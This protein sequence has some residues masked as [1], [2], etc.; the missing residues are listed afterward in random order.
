[1]H[2][3]I[4]DAPVYYGW[5]VTLACFLSNGVV[6]GMTYSFGVFTESLA[7]AFGAS[8]AYTSLVF[9]VQLFVL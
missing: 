3:T 4:S 1:M 5:V 8:T 6:F 7:A 9:G 2:T